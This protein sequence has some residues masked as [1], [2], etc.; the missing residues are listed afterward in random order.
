MSVVA[1]TTLQIWYDSYKAISE[2]C[3]SE[4]YKQ[5]SSKYFF[6]FM[7]VILLLPVQAFFMSL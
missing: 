2:K 3:W 7:H 1:K 5:L 4:T 6:Q